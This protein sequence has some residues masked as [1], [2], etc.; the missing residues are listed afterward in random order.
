M[1]AMHAVDVINACLAAELAEKRRM[2]EGV[3]GE[4]LLRPETEHVLRDLAEDDE[5]A[6]QHLS[7]HGDLLAA[8][9]AN[10][11]ASVFWALEEGTGSERAHDP[12]AMLADLRELAASEPR[13]RAELDRQIRLASRLLALVH[14][15]R[16]PEIWAK[17]Q[18]TYATALLTHTATR[19]GWAMR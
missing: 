16:A 12:H 18:A 17:L 6:T 8:C 4:L 2:L 14:R 5:E 1:P 11:I 10:G 3:E 19:P 15:G 9:R 13:D 7:W